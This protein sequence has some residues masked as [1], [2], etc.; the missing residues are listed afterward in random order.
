MFPM[1]KY[2]VQV[3]LH[4]NNV[5]T[6]WLIVQKR[7]VLKNVISVRAFHVRKYVICSNVRIYT[8]PNVKKYVPMKN[9]V[10]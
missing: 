10:C 4:I 2:A 6:I 1:M 3:V 9:I 7:M 5:P 8:K